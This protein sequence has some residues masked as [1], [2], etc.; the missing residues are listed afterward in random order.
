MTQSVSSTMSPEGLKLAEFQSAWNRLPDAKRDSLQDAL[1]SLVAQRI[2]SGDIKLGMTPD[3]TRTFLQGCFVYAC[4][5]GDSIRLPK[6]KNEVVKFVDSGETYLNERK[7][8]ASNF[9][10]SLGFLTTTLGHLVDASIFGGSPLELAKRDLLPD[11]VSLSNFNRLKIYIEV[12]KKFIVNVAT[13]TIKQLGDI[14]PNE[15]R[16][17]LTS[18]F[19][20]AAIW[21]RGMCLSYIGKEFGVDINPIYITDENLKALSQALKDPNNI[22]IGEEHLTNSQFLEKVSSDMLGIFAQHLESGEREIVYELLWRY[23]RDI[24]DILAKA[25]PYLSEERGEGISM[26]E[27]RAGR[28][29]YLRG[30]SVSLPIVHQ[31]IIVDSTKGIELLETAPYNIWVG[32]EQ[33]EGI[34]I[35]PNTSSLRLCISL[36]ERSGQNENGLVDRLENL[37]KLVNRFSNNKERLAN[38]ETIEDINR[39]ESAFLQT[40]ES[41][42]AVRQ[43]S[44]DYNVQQEIFA[45]Q[46]RMFGY[47]TDILPGRL[48]AYNALM[49]LN[50]PEGTV[51]NPV[52]YENLPKEKKQFVWQQLLKDYTYVQF[53]NN[54]SFSISNREIKFLNLPEL[55]LEDIFIPKGSVL[56]RVS[57]L[58]ALY[59]RISTALLDIR[60]E[61]FIKKALLVPSV[62]DE[63]ARLESEEQRLRFS[64]QYVG[65]EISEHQTALDKIIKD[66]KIKS[67]NSEVKPGRKEQEKL[68]KKL[69]DLKSSK[70]SYEY[71]LEKIQAETKKGYE[72]FVKS[73]V[74]L[75]RL[76]LVDQLF[77]LK[78]LFHKIN[79]AE[80][81]NNF[82]RADVS[83]LDVKKLEKFLG[84]PN[85]TKLN[86][87]FGNT[88]S[89]QRE[90]LMV[91]ASELKDLILS[92]KIRRGG[93]GKEHY[94]R[95]ITDQDITILKKVVESPLLKP[96]N[97]E[98]GNL[99]RISAITRSIFTIPFTK[100][101]RASAIE[102]IEIKAREV[103]TKANAIKKV[104]AQH[105]EYN[106]RRKAVEKLKS[107][108]ETTLAELVVLNG[109]LKDHP[110][111]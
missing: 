90:K 23:S 38:S 96:H 2:Y 106:K 109:V 60:E 66:T 61:K 35:L 72:G 75:F 70:G 80:A 6:N 40:T 3:S 13:S 21:F 53:D 84:K 77:G 74:E 9:L 26:K 42:E 36:I 8:E 41:F 95:Q 37:F 76:H 111:D 102:E 46:R 71:L 67:V 20:L 55:K 7:Q 4:T 44:S 69:R 33:I 34:G 16:K 100:Q 79:K 83:D 57:E 68:E 27:F 18:N 58:R 62:K 47:T 73:R 101:I 39:D 93:L 94:F 1:T 91:Y 59:K 17:R 56:T 10:N 52:E 50:L 43:R 63:F 99:G 11:S 89:Y 64:I 104:I 32:G 81:I 92:L 98:I 45:A 49:S 24:V 103:F 28:E 15:T 87:A 107:D 82:K 54:Y 110:I 5:I 108:R 30:L 14:I 51:L 31:E 25:E 86:I 19:N 48:T 85:I 65:Q 105:E 97:I 88:P 12:S 29:R 78:E 22:R